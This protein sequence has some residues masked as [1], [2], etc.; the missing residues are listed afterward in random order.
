MARR[1]TAQQKAWAKYYIVDYNATQAAISAGYKSAGA[2]SR[3][4]DLTHNALVMAYVERLTA[5]LNQKLE[6]DALYVRQRLVDIDNLNV[7][8]ILTRNGLFLPVQAWP[9]QWCKSISSFEISYDKNDDSKII[10]H[11][12]K[13]PDKIKTLELLGRHISIG[14]WDTSSTLTTDESP[15]LQIIFESAPAKGDIRVTNAGP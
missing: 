10:S 9:E 11:K 13:W 5:K 1:L 8:D 14:A 12:I 6:I 15:T 4:Y 3:G 7:R 2:S